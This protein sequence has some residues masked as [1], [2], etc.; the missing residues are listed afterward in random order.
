MT[1]TQTMH[2]EGEMPQIHHSFA[3]SFL[4]PKNGHLT[5]PRI[6]VITGPHFAGA[7][8]EKKNRRITLEVTKTLK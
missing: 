4:F 7:R 3:S 5:S 2:Y 8:R 6:P 1:P